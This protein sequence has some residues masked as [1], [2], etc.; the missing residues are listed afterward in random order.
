M[1][2]LMGQRMMEKQIPFGNDKQ[3]LRRMM[4]KQIPFGNDNQRQN[5]F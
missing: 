4:W 3:R 1:G 5:L 2:V